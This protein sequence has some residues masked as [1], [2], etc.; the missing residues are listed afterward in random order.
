MT[1]VA[2][3][4]LSRSQTD[5][6]KKNLRVLLKNEY[7]PPKKYLLYKYNASEDTYNIPL[8]W[9]ANNLQINDVKFR[10][11]PTDIADSIVVPREEQVACINECEKQ[12]SKEYG[13]GIINL[14]T[15]SGKTIISIYLLAKY[16]YKT[17]IV[18]N[19]AELLEQWQIALK[20]FIPGVRVGIIRGNTFDCEGCHVVVGMIQTI[21]MRQEYNR[22][23]FKF[24]MVFIDECHHLSSEVFSETLFKA[25][26][27]YVFG[28]SATV[29]RQDGLEYVFKWHIGDILYS[30]INTSK[31]QFTLFKKIDYYGKSSKELT[32]FRGKPNIA[33]M[34][35]A[36]SE[37]SD[38]TTVIVNALNELE[39]ERVVLVLSDRVSQLNYIHKC[40][41]K[42][43]SGLMIGSVSQKERE[44][45]KTKRYILATYQIASE[46]FN[47]PRL[48]TLLFATPRS[49][50]S[51]SI[52]RIYR[53]NHSN[54]SPMI[55]DV[56]DSFSVFVNQYKRRKAVYNKEISKTHEKSVCL[57]D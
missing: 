6:I 8:V 28:L 1:E 22:D 7:G 36:M 27:R 50:V 18:V 20:K 39:P 26:C 45:A 21:S 55:I 11:Y 33:G 47:L 17:L 12:L 9:A 19:T 46:G 24:G 16:K 25:R 41:G 31:K 35:T 40:I 48:N 43:Q 15:G 5:T 57:F 56:V 34:I 37:D 4:N 3:K 42:E 49:T 38:R 14:S 10:K 54:I 29:K 13:G 23:K 52:G 51:Q 32:M 30:N 44:Q 2:A 53:Q